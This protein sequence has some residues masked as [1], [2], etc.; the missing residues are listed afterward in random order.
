VGRAKVVAV[1]EERA[2]AEVTFACGP[3][4]LD[5]IAILYQARPI[6]EYKEADKFDRFV[7]PN[8]KQ[9]GAITAAAFNAG[10]V[11]V[12]R[13]VYINLGELDGVRA[14]NTFRIFHISR[15][16][17]LQGILG[18]P[19]LPRESVGELVVLTT[20]EKSSVGIVVRSIRDISLGDGIELE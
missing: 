9:L 1:R 12:G 14:G 16:Y 11:G 17:L 10:A 4:S 3:V 5:D 7:P 8:G 6:P 19:D 13:M 15:D 20:Q 2:V 18:P